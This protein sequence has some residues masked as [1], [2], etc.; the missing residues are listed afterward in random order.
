MAAG[1]S[2][3]CGSRGGYPRRVE[4][5]V[6]VRLIAAAGSERDRA[7]LTLLWRTGQRIGDWSEVHGQHGSSGCACAIWT[8]RR[9]RWW[10]G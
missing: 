2:I 8:G 3:G 9:G 5:E 6:A 7:L 10:C 4:P 1:V